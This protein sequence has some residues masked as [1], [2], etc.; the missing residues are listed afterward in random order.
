MHAP[1]ACLHKPA[2]SGTCGRPSGCRPVSA[3]YRLWKGATVL[4]RTCLTIIVDCPSS[5]TRSGPPCITSLVTRRMAQHP[6]LVSSCG[7]FQ[8]SAQPCY[9]TSMICHG[10]GNETR[11]WRSLV[12]A[13]GCPALRGYPSSPAYLSPRRAPVSGSPIVFQ[14]HFP[15]IYYW[16]LRTNLRDRVKGIE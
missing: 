2:K 12:D 9:R 15:G 11:P 16:F 5:A 7:R 6:H 13:T 10:L 4:C 8:I 14:R 1:K 3:P